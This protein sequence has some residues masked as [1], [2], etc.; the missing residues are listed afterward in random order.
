MKSK[1]KRLLLVLG[2][3][4]VT[5]IAGWILTR[6]P[7]ALPTRDTTAT[8]NSEI[9]APSDTE[10]PVTAPPKNEPVT[11]VP[12][13]GVVDLNRILAANARLQHFEIEHRKP[14]YANE[15]QSR[16][17]G[18]LSNLFLIKLR[19]MRQWAIRDDIQPIIAARAAAHNIPIVFDRNA[20]TTNGLRVVLLYSTTVSNLS[21]LANA[22]GVIDLTEEVLR[23]AAR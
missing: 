2:L 21:E 6:E 4:C 19:A 12:W 7:Q 22:P 14:E 11:P 23:E 9:T 13:L 1:Q 16:Y 15:F 3:A 18:E 17:S 20:N 10:E 5:A 8:P